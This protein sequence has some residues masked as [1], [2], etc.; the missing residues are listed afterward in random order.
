MASDCFSLQLA[1]IGTNAIG[2]NYIL[3]P[4]DSNNGEMR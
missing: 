2:A 4:N 1:C 3:I